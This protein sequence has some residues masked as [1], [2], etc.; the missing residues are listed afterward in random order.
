M[1]IG[2][3]L[4]FS[5]VLLPFLAPAQGQQLKGAMEALRLMRTAPNS[6]QKLGDAVAAFVAASTGMTPE[7]AG[8]EWATRH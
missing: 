6:K 4:A 8:K 2:K 7:Q 1:A 3:S 5:L